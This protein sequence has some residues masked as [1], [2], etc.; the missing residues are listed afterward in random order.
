LSQASE[1]N[2]LLIRP[3]IT[4]LCATKSIHISTIK[5]SRLN[6]LEECFIYLKECLAILT[7][8][9]PP[10]EHFYKYNSEN[11]I[12]ARMKQLRQECKLKLQLCAILS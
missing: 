11:C 2:T 8:P 1:T 4:W 6:M 5:H 12:A 10:G 7:A 3:S 9:L